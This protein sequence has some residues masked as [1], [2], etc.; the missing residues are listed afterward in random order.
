M[1]ET[2]RFFNDREFKNDSKSIPSENILFQVNLP[3]ISAFDQF[4]KQINTFFR[5]TCTNS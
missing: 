3:A 2:T 1:K 4:F 5:W